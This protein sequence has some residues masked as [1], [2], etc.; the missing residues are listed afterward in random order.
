[1]RGRLR[2]VE[3]GGRVVSYAVLIFYDKIS[4]M[5]GGEACLGWGDGWGWWWWVYSLGCVRAGSGGRGG[6]CCGAVDS[7][8]CGGQWWRRGRSG[9][10]LFGFAKLADGML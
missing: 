1:M 7:R 8:H 5:T 10:E 9:F 4:T 3:G 6:F 2:E